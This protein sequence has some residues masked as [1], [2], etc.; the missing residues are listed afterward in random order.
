M[1][2]NQKNVPGIDEISNLQS[3]NLQNHGRCIWDTKADLFE[4]QNV[5]EGLLVQKI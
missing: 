4:L 3:N 5:A 1:H 2:A